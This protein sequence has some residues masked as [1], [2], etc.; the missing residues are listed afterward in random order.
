MGSIRRAAEALAISP[1]A[2]NRQILAVEEDLGVEIF[3][4]LPRGVRLSTAGEIYLNCFRAHLA[5]LHR[6]ASQVADLSGL[7][8]GSVS[9]GVTEELASNFVSDVVAKYQCAYP[10]VDIAMR[11]LPAD[12]ISGALGRFDIDLGL[13]VNWIKDEAVEA[14]HAEEVEVICISSAQGDLP[15]EINLSRLADRPLIAPTRASGLRDHIDAALAFRGVPKRYAQ[16]TDRLARAM[17][18]AIPTSVQFALAIDNPP[19]QTASA[20]LQRHKLSPVQMPPATVSVL[21]LR[22]RPLPVASAKLASDL[23]NALARAS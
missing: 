13:A 6:A 9:I 15:A 7:R 1:S 5:D 14:I 11:V 20:T 10:L 8:A 3:E 18:A 16:E 21:S 17:L 23:S 22:Y 19:E 12:E 2:L 4:R